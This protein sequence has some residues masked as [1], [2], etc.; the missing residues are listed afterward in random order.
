M[1]ENL[2]S[3]QA[4]LNSMIS[5]RCGEG[6]PACPPLPD[7]RSEL[8][9]VDP[10]ASLATPASSAILESNSDSHS[11]RVNPHWPLRTAEDWERFRE[12]AMEDEVMREEGFQQEAE[13]LPS[14][15]VWH[16]ALPG[17]PSSDSEFEGKLVEIQED[18]EEVSD[19]SEDPPKEVSSL[20]FPFRN[21]I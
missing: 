6:S 15:A 9:Y 18:E 2:D 12:A 8:S 5:C 19:K 11:S 20:P 7:D 10:N 17:A 13:E 3:H 14:P 21:K 1:G 4:R 16:D